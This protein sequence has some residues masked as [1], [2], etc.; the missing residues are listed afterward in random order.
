MNSAHLAP[1]SQVQWLRMGAFALLLM[2]FVLLPFAL[3]SE[4]F[5]HAAPQ[6]LQAQNGEWRLA[7]AGIALL[8]ADVVLPIPSSIV[9]MALCWE[10]GPVRGGLSVAIGCLLAFVVGYG[11]GRLTPEPRLRRW[12]G[13]RLWDSAQ[14]HARQRAMWWIVVARPLPLLAE[15]SALLAGVWRIPLL[16]ALTNAAAASSVV[17]ALYGA[18]A[19]LGRDQPAVGIMLLA[20]LALPLLTWCLHRLVLRRWLRVDVPTRPDAEREVS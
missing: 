13:P 11:I 3:W 10:L 16:P 1:P 17:G 14:H 19:W 5:D 15:I 9:G 8:I 7:T 2:T 12:I 18:S 20:L 6:W 4:A